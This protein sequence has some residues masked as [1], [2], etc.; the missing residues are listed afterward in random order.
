MKKGLF[1]IY[2]LFAAHFTLMAQQSEMQ[3]RQKISRIASSIK[4]MSC[5]FIQTKHLKMLNDDMVSKGRMYY[6]Q[7]NRLRWEYTSPYTYT[8]IINNDKVLLKNSQRNDVIDVNSNKLFKEI[9]RIMMN[10][11]VGNCLNDETSFKSSI[12][13]SGEEWV[14]TLLPQRKDMKQ[15]FQKIVLH[16]SQKQAVVTQVELIEKN[17]DRT[18]I[19][20]KNIKTNETISANMFTIR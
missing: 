20:L 7:S 19:D 4:T 16:F 15:M 3:I 18:I 17:G 14:A 9:A 11:V 8:F 6:Q 5:D 13:V 2:L 1:I 12:S 10:S